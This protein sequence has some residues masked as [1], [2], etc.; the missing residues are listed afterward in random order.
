MKDTLKKEAQKIQD[1]LE[2]HCSDEPAEITERI[3]TISVYMARSGEM[4]AQA[5]RLYNQK[6]TSEIGRTIVK[7]AKEQFLSAT[8]QNALV[9]SIGEEEMFLVD[10]IDRINKTCT[11]QME[12]LRTLLS[13]EKEQMKLNRTGY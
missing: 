13:Y 8:A 7:I 11:H 2:I 4:L 12:A 10:W 1:Y 9:K 3:K 5:K 6:T